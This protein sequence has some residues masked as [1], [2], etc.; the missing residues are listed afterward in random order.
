[1]S[2]ITIDTLAGMMKTSFEHLEKKIEDFRDE[3]RSEFRGELRGVKTEIKTISDKFD[4]L[5]NN[6]ERRISVLED[7]MRVVKT[8]L[9]K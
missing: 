6:H 4:K 5:E 8:K 7:D 3:L 9:N 2:K 1:M